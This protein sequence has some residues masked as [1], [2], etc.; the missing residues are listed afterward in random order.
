MLN[1]KNAIGRIAINNDI[2]YYKSQFLGIYI[3][4]RKNEFCMVF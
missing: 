4:K 2:L 1:S 3:D